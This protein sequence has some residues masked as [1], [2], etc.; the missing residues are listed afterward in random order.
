MFPIRHV[1]DVNR[2]VPVRPAEP[3]SVGQHTNR[4]RED[5]GGGEYN[6]VQIRA[7]HE[8]H[9]VSSILVVEYFI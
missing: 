2:Q 5:T 8:R 9:S 3:V 4:N 6:A 7:H 1:G